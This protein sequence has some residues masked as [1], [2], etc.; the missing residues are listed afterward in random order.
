MESWNLKPEK[1]YGTKLYLLCALISILA[2]G[3]SI[4]MGWL[5][6][7]DAGGSDGAL[8]GIL[9]SIGVNLLWIIPVFIWI[10]PYRR[11]LVYEI[12]AD[13]VIVR[14]GVVTKTVKHVPFRT[15]TNIEI[16]RGPLDRLFMIGTVKIQTAGMSGQS[17]AEEMLVGLNNYNE[18]YDRIAVNL[19][20][21]R[22][23]MSPDQ[24]G[25]IP[26]TGVPQAGSAAD[27]LVEI[28]TELR[29]I[30]STLAED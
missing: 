26:G 18:V 7:S 3:F 2:L 17:G 27:V 21:F 6:G 5:I 10:G 14:G 16:N 24:A 30:R 28:L 29:A 19:R 25:V 11:S 20:K 1:S 22:A 9:I 13:E 15:V 4:L 23:A 12:E 8:T